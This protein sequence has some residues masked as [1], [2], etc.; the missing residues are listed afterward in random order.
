MITHTPVRCSTN[1]YVRVLGV[2]NKIDPTIYQVIKIGTQKAYLVR[3]RDRAE[4]VFHR[5][6][7]VQTVPQG[8]AMS[9]ISTPTIESTP[10]KRGRKPKPR[11]PEV[12]FVFEE[13]VRLFGQDENGRWAEHWTKQTEFDLNLDTQSH[14]IIAPDRSRF[15]YF[16]T[17][18][19]KPNKQFHG[20]DPNKRYG[21]TFALSDY[22]KQVEK[23]TR[24][25]YS[26]TEYPNLQ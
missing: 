9:E 25:G 24:K 21:R 22:D 16:A 13:Y 23:M 10:R 7:I 8:E 2:N 11:P 3:L 17:Y 12:P 18:N 26:R 6:R 19:G 1:D 4:K 14:I 15:W 5:T 20:L